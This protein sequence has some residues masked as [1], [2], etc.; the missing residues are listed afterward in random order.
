MTTRLK[1]KREPL[2]TFWHYVP[3]WRFYI[4]EGFWLLVQ[5]TL[6]TIFMVWLGGIVHDIVSPPI[7][8]T[9]GAVF[10]TLGLDQT[11]LSRSPGSR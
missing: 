9:V 10:E 1:R 3:I 7:R 4:V 5:I 6:L 2:V 11:G 8:A